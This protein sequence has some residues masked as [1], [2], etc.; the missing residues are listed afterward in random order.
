MVTMVPPS[1][2]HWM[3]TRPVCASM[4]RFTAAQAGDYQFCASLLGALAFEMDLYING[5]REN[6]FAG[7]TGDNAYSHGCRTVRL[8]A[9]NY[10]E[11]W[12]DAA[13]T[14]A[15]TTYPANTYWDW[16][17]VSKLR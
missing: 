13:A 9:G 8:A 14:T 11:I 12:A 6:A 17:V 7:G 15:L 4:S 1:G 10:V 16:L 5:T 3:S 2:G